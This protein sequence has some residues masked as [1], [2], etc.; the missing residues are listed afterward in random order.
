MKKYFF[1][2]IL[3]FFFFSCKKNQKKY[4]KNFGFAQGTSFHIIYENDMNLFQEI[5]SLLLEFDNS[6]SIYNKNSIISKVN[7]NEKVILD[8]YFK[9]LFLKSKEI[10]KFSN[11][12]FD[13]TVAPLVNAWGFGLKNKENITKNLIDS[14]LQFVGFEKITLKDGKIFKENNKI[15]LN[16]NAIAQG[17]SV[18]IVSY[19]LEKNNI[20]NYLV[21]IGGEVK[22]KG[23]NEK[24]KAWRI[25]IDK[26]LENTNL[27]DRELQIILELNNKSLATS[28][29]YRNFY[30]EK[31]VKYSHTINPKTGYPVRDSLL[32]VTVITEDCIFADAIA[33][34]FMVMGLEKTKIFLEKNTNL[35]AYLIYND[36]GKIKTFS[37]KNF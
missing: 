37:T 1:I 33:T 32:S 29:S 14:I 15:T 26:P 8:N 12:Y 7:R 21:E 20:K 28:G 4:F 6:L 5:D 2:I 9:T 19:F 3:I 30:E 22:V 18:D 31:G 34:A 27:S 23:F 35:Q 11:S 36:K 16:A 10:H 24:S 25:G 13:L 17:Y